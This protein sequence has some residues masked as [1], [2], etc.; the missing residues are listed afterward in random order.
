MYFIDSMEE[1]IDVKRMIADAKRDP[2]LVASI[3]VSTLLDSLENTKNDY[4]EGNTLKTIASAVYDSLLHL[5]IDT[6]IRQKYCQKLVGY[7]FVDEI[8][9]LH[10]GKHVRWIR[11]S[12]P[13]KLMI[14]GIVVDIKFTENGVIVL[15]RLHS[16]KFTQYRFDQCLTYQ[17]LTDDEQL[18]LMLYEADI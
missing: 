11:L 7:R 17:K 3:H 1:R 15:C 10:Q 8:Y 18:I 4:L 12:S 13:E 14:G 6:P 16:G 9:Q 5:P 2:T